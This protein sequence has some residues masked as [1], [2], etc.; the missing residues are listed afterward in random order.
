[1]RRLFRSLIEQEY[2]DFSVVLVDQNPFGYLDPILREFSGSLNHSVVRIIEA[3][4]SNARNVGMR[5]LEGD[6]I[7]FPDDDCFYDARTLSR[8]VEAFR[9]TPQCDVL[10]G[11]L[12][13]PLEASVD[14]EQTD[15]HFELTARSRYSVFKNAGTAVH[16]YRRRT[17][18]AVGLFDERLGP[19][20]G[21]PYVS[22]EDTDY[23][24]RA[25]DLGFTVM[26]CP[27]VNVYHPPV[28]TGAPNLSAKAY[29]YGRGRG[30]ILRKH[31]F[32]WWF[33]GLN[34]VHPVLTMPGK[35]LGLIRYKWH[36]LRGRMAELFLRDR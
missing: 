7:A 2:K 31:S 32:P 26:G 1:M 30:F 20:A 29:G 25:V 21:T 23:L 24:V 14:F 11:C 4:A 9:R 28:A 33:V 18:D 8:V 36:M 13:P 6:I 3:G 12:R 5:P 16:F 19:G 27:V 17:V 22:G 34:L 15:A 10:I 35:D